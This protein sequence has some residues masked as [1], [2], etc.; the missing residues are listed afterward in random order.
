MSV[1]GSNGGWCAPPPTPWGNAMR[2]PAAIS[3]VLCRHGPGITWLMAT[4]I[5]PLVALGGGGALKGVCGLFPPHCGTAGCGNH[6]EQI[7][8]ANS[9]HDAVHGELRLYVVAL[10]LVPFLN[11]M[12]V[13]TDYRDHWKILWFL[14]LLI[15]VYLLHSLF[16][17]LMGLNRAHTI[18]FAKMNCI[19]SSL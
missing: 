11:G 16:M 7:H 9:S 12:F 17:V 13:F 4:A 18:N 5:H 6:R 10:P 1:G 8:Q 15:S 14:G 3:A 2:A 19:W